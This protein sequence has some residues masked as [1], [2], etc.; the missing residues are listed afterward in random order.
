[1][2][3]K[4]SSNV[5]CIYKDTSRLSSLLFL[6][7][8]SSSALA[9]P[10]KILEF[11]PLSLPRRELSRFYRNAKLHKRTL[12]WL[13]APLGSKSIAHEKFMRA[14]WVLPSFLFTLPIRK[15]TR[16]S[17]GTSSFNSSSSFSASK[18]RSEEKR[19]EA[20]WNLQRGFRGSWRIAF[21]KVTSACE[22]C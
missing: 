16:L 11:P 22:E 5:S 19:T 21:S 4:P 7:S 8:I 13:F 17:R 1:M 15:Y 12:I 20:L 6:P 3:I 9:T 14:R 18:C 10:V 2:K